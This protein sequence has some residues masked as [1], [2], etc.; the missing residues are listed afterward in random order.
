LLDD[1]SANSAGCARLSICSGGGSRRRSSASESRPGGAVEC[2]YL[3]S[4]IS[5]QIK[6]KPIIRKPTAA[7][8]MEMQSKSPPSNRNVPAIR[9]D[10]T[11]T[12]KNNGHYDGCSRPD[13]YKLTMRPPV[14]TNALLNSE[15]ERWGQVIRDN[16]SYVDQ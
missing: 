13:K 14:A 16:N 5:R 4:A 1:T 6:P 3:R 8:T 7:Q 12:G 2:F 11:K 15:I 9:I 10:P